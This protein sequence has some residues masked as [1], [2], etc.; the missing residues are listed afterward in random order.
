MSVTAN[1]QYGA[2]NS[3][4]NQWSEDQKLTNYQGIRYKKWHEIAEGIIRSTEGPG[5]YLLFEKCKPPIQENFR[6]D[7]AKWKEKTEQWKNG[8]LRVFQIF[9]NGI[10]RI[11]SHGG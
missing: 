6:G 11:H 3:G 10:V 2:S 4:T 7:I 5:K 1:S 9:T 8:K